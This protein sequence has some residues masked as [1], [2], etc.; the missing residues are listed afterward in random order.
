ME[1]KEYVDEKNIEVWF[2]THHIDTFKSPIVPNA[3]EDVGSG[4]GDFYSG[5]RIVISTQERKL[6]MSSKVENAFPLAFQFL[7]ICPGEALVHL[8][9]YIHCNI[10]KTRLEVTHVFLV[11]VCVHKFWYIQTSKCHSS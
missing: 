4:K 11:G 5:V 7:S 1:N 8:Y 10:I 2:Y 6:A 9:K 3:V